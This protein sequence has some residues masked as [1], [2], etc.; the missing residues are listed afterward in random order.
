MAPT[1]TFL[2]YKEAT[3]LG[4]QEETRMEQTF[5]PISTLRARLETRVLFRIGS[6]PKL[7]AANPFPKGIHDRFH[8]NPQIIPFLASKVPAFLRCV[9]RQGIQKGNSTALE[10][11]P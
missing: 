6:K 2:F 8:L 5:F 11:G 10:N 4:I 1:A 3:K 7:Q 9:S